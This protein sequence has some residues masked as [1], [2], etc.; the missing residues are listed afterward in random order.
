MGL[1]GV[2]HN[3]ATKQ[4]QQGSLWMGVAGSQRQEEDASWKSPTPRPHEAE[5]SHADVARCSP[6][7]AISQCFLAW[8][9][10]GAQLQEMLPLRGA[11]GSS[12]LGRAASALHRGLY[13]DKGLNWSLW[14]DPLGVRAFLPPQFQPQI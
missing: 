14:P 5:M 3:L 4:Q 12:G 7:G 9:W 6:T 11:A 1:Q 10:A 2:G 13:C 8:I